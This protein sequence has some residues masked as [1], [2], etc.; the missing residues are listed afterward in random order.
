MTLSSYFSY[1]SVLQY[2]FQTCVNQDNERTLHDELAK[3]LALY[4]KQQDS[5]SISLLL[6][7]SKGWGGGVG[8]RQV[9]CVSPCVMWTCRSEYPH[10][11]L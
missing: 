8:I 9:S 2:V 6:D 7:V 3:Q 4:L 1:P 11:L 10:F 5:N